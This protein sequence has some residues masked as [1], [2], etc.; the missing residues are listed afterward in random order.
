MDGEI[1]LPAEWDE[2]VDAGRFRSDHWALV[3]NTTS[4]Q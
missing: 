1:S 2:R 3:L 4:T